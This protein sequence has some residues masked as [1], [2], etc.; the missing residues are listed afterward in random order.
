MCIDARGCKDRWLIMAKASVHVRAAQRAA[1][2]ARPRATASF[3]RSVAASSRFEPALGGMRTRSRDIR[4]SQWVAVTGA[5]SGPHAGPGLDACTR[6]PTCAA[7]ACCVT[8]TRQAGSALP[9]QPGLPGNSAGSCR[10]RSC[11]LHPWL[12]RPPV[13]EWNRNRHGC[14]EPNTSGMLIAC[15]SE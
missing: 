6:A 3:F 14:G 15:G 11:S 2:R 1:R 10:T 8:R 9:G 5:G 12:L 7:A 13:L 4:V